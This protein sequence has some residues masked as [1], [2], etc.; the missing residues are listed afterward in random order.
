[1]C[2]TCVSSYMYES[3]FTVGGKQPKALMELRAEAAANE[4]AKLRSQLCSH[5]PV[6]HFTCMNLSLGGKGQG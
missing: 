5:L 4:A 6:F 3:T 1:V 2:V